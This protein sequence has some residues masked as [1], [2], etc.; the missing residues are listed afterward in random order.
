[1]K[2]SFDDD[3]GVLTL[4][5]ETEEDS[6]S[7]EEALGKSY[8]EA[9]ERGYRYAEKASSHHVILAEDGVSAQFSIEKAW[10]NYDD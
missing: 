9:D 2:V 3:R 5:P 6:A 1:M 4:T 7:L 10:W 8:D